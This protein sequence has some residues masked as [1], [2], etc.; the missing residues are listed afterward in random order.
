MEPF[1]MPASPILRLV[2]LKRLSGG[3]EKVVMDRFTFSATSNAYTTVSPASYS[4]GDTISV[5]IKKVT[6]SDAVTRY[7]NGYF[8]INTPDLE[9]GQ[10]YSFLADAV[11]LE[12]KLGSMQIGIASVGVGSTEARADIAAG[13]IKIPFVFT[14]RSGSDDKYLEFH[15]G[16]KSMELS[17]IKI[18]QAE[19]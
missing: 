16:G 11:V 1:W 12:D 18:V 4:P 7:T 19:A 13:K 10:A 9:F 5:T 2:W 17:N 3:G 8:S 15:C 14:K 6:P